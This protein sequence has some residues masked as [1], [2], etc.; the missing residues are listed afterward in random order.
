MNKPPDI[1]DALLRETRLRTRRVLWIAF[2]GSSFLLLLLV[3]ILVGSGWWR[4]AGAA[5][6]FTFAYQFVVG[7]RREFRPG[8][9]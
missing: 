1:E 2:G 7:F 6:A 8:R 4:I 3:L 9:R 5:F